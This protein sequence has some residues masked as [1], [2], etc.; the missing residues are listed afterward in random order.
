MARNLAA[1]FGNMDRLLGGQPGG[2]PG[3]GGGG[4]LTARAIL[5]T[6]KDPAFRDLVR[7]LKEAGVE[8]EAKEK[9]GRPLKGSP[10]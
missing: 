7:R 2:A 5:E 4:E 1:R 9:G 6:L 10:S 8:M 3:G